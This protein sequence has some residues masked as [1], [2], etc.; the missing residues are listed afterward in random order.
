MKMKMDLGS[1][2]CDDENAEVY[3]TA[4]EVWY[5]GVDQNCDGADDY[6]QDG[7]GYVP[8]IYA[9]QSSLEAGDCNDENAEVYPTAV[10]VWYDGVDQNCDGADDMT[11]MAMGMSLSSMH[12]RAVCCPVTVMMRTAQ[13]FLT[14]EPVMHHFRI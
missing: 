12:R 6:D 2:D 7:D 4:E 8:E 1:E 11:K 14:V 13:S 5:D 10:E 3:P 9:S